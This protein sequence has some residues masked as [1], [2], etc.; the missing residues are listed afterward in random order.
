MVEE[1]RIELMSVGF[2]APR[3]NT[4]KII[5]NGVRRF[6]D[7]IGRHVNIAGGHRVTEDQP[8]PYQR[9]VFLVGG[10]RV[11][12]VG[13]ADGT[14]ISSRLQKLLDTYED[15]RHIKVENYGCYL[16]ELNDASIGEELA[17]I[18]ALPVMDGDI[19][20]SDIAMPEGFAFVDMGACA[21][22]PHPYGEVFF[23][24]QHYTGEG[25]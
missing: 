7:I 20:L 22:R 1:T 17:I 16:A 18:H 9:T 12:G 19:I 15:S 23:D 6:A 11:F 21:N 13:S 14:T 4:A 3:A 2:N 10:C 25:N 24:T 5:I 8:Q